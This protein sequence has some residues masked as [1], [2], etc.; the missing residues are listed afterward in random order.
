MIVVRDREAGNVI[1]IVE[2]IKKGQ[3]LIEKYEEMD[4]RAGLYTPN[5]Y[6]VAEAEDSEVER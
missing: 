4:K 5:F 3:E 2:S 6:E 1:E